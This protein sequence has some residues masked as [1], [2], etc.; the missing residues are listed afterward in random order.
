MNTRK[1]NEFR[2]AGVIRTGWML[3]MAG[4]LLLIA[5]AIVFLADD[6]ELSDHLGDRLTIASWTDTE[7]IASDGRRIPL[8]Y[9]KIM[10]ASS[11]IFDC[12]LKRGVSIDKYGNSV[13]QVVFN[14]GHKHVAINVHFEYFASY[15]NDKVSSSLPIS[16]MA[17]ELRNETIT[18]RGAYYYKMDG[19]LNGKRVEYCLFYSN[20]YYTFI[21]WQKTILER[22]GDRS[23]LVESMGGRVPKVKFQN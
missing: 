14:L 15:I 4:V 7:L 23:D 5:L 19:Y 1:A 22:T 16:D 13:C 3:A 17:R 21:D 12:I 10:P 20:V 6:D 9:I 8:K 11:P 18:D 2:T